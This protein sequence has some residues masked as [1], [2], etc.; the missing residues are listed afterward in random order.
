MQIPGHAPP[1]SEA[2]SR[3]GGAP[4][5]QTFVKRFIE[6]FK[7]DID[8][9]Q[10]EWAL[11]AH[12]LTEGYQIAP[13]AITFQ[14][15]K[16]LGASSPSVQIQLKADRGWQSSGV[17][18]E[19]GKKYTVTASG[20]FTLASKPKPWI[21]EADGISFRYFGGQP[22]GKLL[23]CIRLHTAAAIPTAKGMRQGFPCGANHTFVAP[24]TGT[25]YLR[26][27]DA[28]NQLSDNTGGVT[29]DV[30]LD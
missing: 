21:S 19:Q 15:G 26:L 18:V 14:P 16:A 24:Q 6:D 2:V 28:W 23:G 29:V 3:A 9:M 20:R 11:F 22:L 30:R 1:L 27:N 5:F 7:A 10:T 8:D 17:L 13:A 4:T 12:N 25:L